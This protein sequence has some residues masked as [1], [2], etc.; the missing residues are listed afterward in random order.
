MLQKSG[1]KT[2]VWMVLKLCKWWDKLPYQLVIA[3]FLPSTVE[4]T[5]TTGSVIGLV[6]IGIGVEFLQ[7]ISHLSQMGMKHENYI[8]KR[9]VSCQT[10]ERNHSKEPLQEGFTHFRY[11]RQSLMITMS[12]S[13][14]IA[15]CKTLRLKVYKFEI[16]QRLKYLAVEW[17]WVRFSKKH[18]VVY[19]FCLLNTFFGANNKKHGFLKV[20]VS[21]LVLQH[22]DGCK[23]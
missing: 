22:R 4:P 8:E 1:E 2:T 16:S 10:L 11:E 15:L 13:Q 7:R 17:R 14:R 3:G 5:G 18:H 6:S 20:P 9:M 12:F 21:P 19:F 23:K